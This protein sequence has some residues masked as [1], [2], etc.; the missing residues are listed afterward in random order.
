M[1]SVSEHKVVKKI[2]IYFPFI[3]YFICFFFSSFVYVEHSPLT[4]FTY[5][6]IRSYQEL[7]HIFFIVTFISFSLT[8][9][10]IKLLLVFCLFYL[11]RYERP[12][13]FGEMLQVRHFFPFFLFFHTALVK[14]FFLL[15][16]RRRKGVG[17]GV[18]VRPQRHRD[19]HCLIVGQRHRR[20]R[21]PH[22]T[23]HY[24]LLLGL[25]FLLPRKRRI[26]C[27]NEQKLICRAGKLTFGLVKPFFFFNS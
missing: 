4:Q 21:V 20:P 3:Q 6:D 18:S 16:T 10:H 23:A 19:V 14:L 15:H 11:A 8:F 12:F 9:V 26:F 2:P 5:T 1:K 25:R 17:D 24:L 7:S 13:A 22:H 27:I